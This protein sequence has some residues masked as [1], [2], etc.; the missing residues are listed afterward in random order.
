MSNGF[1]PAELAVAPS[2]P[3]V[4]IAPATPVIASSSGGWNNPELSGGTRSRNGWACV[5]RFGGVGD[6]LMAA[7]VLPGLRKKYGRV[8]VIS[9]LP[10]SCVFEHNPYVDKL[11]ISDKQFIPQDSSTNWQ[12]WFLGRSL[13]YDAFY[14]LSHSCETMRALFVGQTQFWWPASFRRKLCF[15]NYL[16]TVHDICEVPYEFE[17]LFYQ[18]EPERDYHIDTKRKVGEKCIAWVISGTRIDKTHPHAPMIIARLIKEVGP[19]VMLGGPAP[20]K[21]FEHA[22]LIQEMVIRYNGDDKG[23]HLGLSSDPNNPNWP[24]R[25]VL[26]FSQHCDL[27]ITPDTGPAWACAFND[28]PKIMLLSHA[29]EENITKHWTKTITLH[30]DRA[31]VSCFPC[32]QLH[33]S[34]DTCT[35]NRA[36]DGAACISDIST[37]CIVMAAQAAFGGD[38]LAL[39]NVRSKYPSNVMLSR[40]LTVEQQQDA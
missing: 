21:D 11:S 31:R 39:E 16:E 12:K 29:S 10:Q 32:H 38:L 18:S 17:S 20:S 37:Q 27:V 36:K 6:N 28:M 35:P 1:F 13:E 9:G 2:S 24:I 30:A 3:A 19:V 22:K 34:G 40:D 8:E 25:R 26:G 23:L 7:S 33:D 15:Q 5:A 4:G 14:H